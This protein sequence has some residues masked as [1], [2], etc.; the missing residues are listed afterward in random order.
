MGRGAL[1]LL[2]RKDGLEEASV[3][4]RVS[5]LVFKVSPCQALPWG[6]R[7]S[8]GSKQGPRRAY[9]QPKG[10]SL[11]PICFSLSGGGKPTFTDGTFAEQKQVL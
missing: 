7:P 10:F 2:S 5:K 11:T 6:N 4:R 8:W 9:N 3:D 1:H